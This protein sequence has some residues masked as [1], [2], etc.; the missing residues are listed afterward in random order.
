M[1]PKLQPDGVRSAVGI[2]HE[3]TPVG[4]QVLDCSGRTRRAGRPD[5]DGLAPGPTEALDDRRDDRCRCQAAIAGDD[6]RRVA[7][8]GLPAL[9]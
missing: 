6:R 7:V 8:H 5:V 3:N 4:S 1:G 2:A 9:T